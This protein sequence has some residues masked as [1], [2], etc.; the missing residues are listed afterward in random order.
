MG[1]ISNTLFLRV[2]RSLPS[3]SNWTRRTANFTGA[4][5]KACELC[6][7]I[8]TAPRLKPLLTAARATLAPGRTQRNG[9]WAS[10]SMLTAAKF[11]WTQKGPDNAGQGRIFRANLEIPKGQTP[12]DRKDIEVLYEDL[13]EP[14]DLD[15][16]LANRMMYWTDRGDPPRGNTVNRAPMDAATGNRKDP[17]IVFERLDGRD[18]IVSGSEKSVACSSLIWAATFTAPISMDRTRRCCF[19]P[20]GI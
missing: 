14:I 11:Y 6:A 15:L 17:E 12:A 16:D 8:S 9:A 4:I 18:R 2:A 5:A 13:P 10:L 1:K 7:A 19:L 3:S 20:K